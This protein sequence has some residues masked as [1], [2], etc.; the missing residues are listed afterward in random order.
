[1]LPLGALALLA[2]GLALAAGAAVE[3]GRE[4]LLAGEPRAAE[5]AFRHARRWPGTAARAESGLALARALRG[6]LTDPA[7]TLAALDPFAPVALLDLALDREDLGGARAI[8]ALLLRA[9]HPLGPLYAGAVALEQGR[10]DEASR[11]AA[12]S[13]VPLASRAVGRRLA[14]ALEL[15]AAG[16]S[17]VVRDRRGALV[18]GLDAEGR[19]ALA[20][21]LDPLLLPPFR[22]TAPRRRRPPEPEVA[23]PFWLPSAEA[24]AATRTGGLRLALDL[25]LA[26]VALDALGRWRGTI[27][28]VEPRTGSV[29]ATVSDPRTRAREGAAAFRQRREPASISKILTAA[30]A[31]RSGIDANAAIGRMTCRGVEFFNGRPLWCSWKAGPLDGLDHALAISCNTS[32]AR[33]GVRIGRDRLVDELRRWGFDAGEDELMGAA[34]RVH[35]PP[36]NDRQLADLSVGLTLSDITPLH[37]A[38]LAT[39]MANGGTMPEP[40]VVA[41]VCGPVGLSNRL[42]VLPPVRKVLGPRTVPPLLRAMRAVA[43]Y[44]TGTGLAPRSFPIAMKTGTA[45]EYRKGYHVNYI[46]IA[47]T[48]DAAVAF[49]VRITYRPNSRSVNLAAR[50]V[51]R[52]LLAGLADHRIS[53]DTEARRL[54]AHAAWASGGEE[55]APVDESAPPEGQGG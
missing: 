50:E 10:S 17:A 42:A 11:L 22:D 46:G 2:A 3:E 25:D 4:R 47:P 13:P 51:T 21:G 38:L 34:G 52:A 7:P 41:N 44:G 49:C 5:A 14:Q 23:A 8:S 55:P 12:A 28:L 35:T 53:L 19:L 39:V 37:A 36:R 6:H 40:R 43:L 9:G 18:G 33:L 24:R 15:R 20:E 29:L 45:A 26:R 27:V 32:F 30:A 16:S 31:Y 1:M 48:P 54:R